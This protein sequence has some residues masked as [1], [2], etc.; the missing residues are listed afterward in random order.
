MPFFLLKPAFIFVDESN[1]HTYVNRMQKTYRSKRRRASFQ[2]RKHARCDDYFQESNSNSGLDWFRRFL[3][4]LF[5]IQMIDWIRVGKSALLMKNRFWPSGHACPY[6]RK[7]VIIYYWA[8]NNIDLI[9]KKFHH[10]C[11]HWIPW[12]CILFLMTAAYWKSLWNIAVIDLNF[13]M[14]HGKTKTDWTS[15]TLLSWWYHCEKIAKI[16]VKTIWSANDWKCLVRRLMSVCLKTK[17]GR[18][19][20]VTKR[21]TCLTL[22]DVRKMMFDFVQYSK[23]YLTHYKMIEFIFIYLQWSNIKKTLSW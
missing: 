21:Q 17:I 5:S 15:F 10:F 18:S 12:Y 23:Q 3:V 13:R 1:T 20:L 11:V 6:V 19:I 7:V 8:A 9:S 22:F 14:S 2:F 16:V 4:N